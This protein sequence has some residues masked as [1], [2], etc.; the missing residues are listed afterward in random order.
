M[1]TFRY[2]STEKQKRDTSW[3]LTDAKAF[4]ISSPELP[5]TAPRLAFKE[6]R[7]TSQLE[8]VSTPIPSVWR[9]CMKWWHNKKFT[10]N[11]VGASDRGGVAGDSKAAGAGVEASGVSP[12]HLTAVQRVVLRRERQRLPFL[13]KRRPTILIQIRQKLTMMHYSESGQ[14]RNQSPKCKGSAHQS[15]LWVDGTE[16]TMLAQ[17]GGVSH[18]GRITG[19]N[20][21]PG[22]APRIG[23]WVEA[24]CQG[25]PNVCVWVGGVSWG[26]GWWQDNKGHIW[27]MPLYCDDFIQPQFTTAPSTTS[28][29]CSHS[30]KVIM[31][32]P[33]WL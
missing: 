1:I 2:T 9:C 8:P 19:L 29:T 7:K 4:P 14:D 5:G 11:G 6:G 21:W 30:T 16:G 26:G 27:D 12:I 25:A 15:V 33:N 17:V 28:L 18:H 22:R 10:H 24:F 31:W 23:G 32:Q 13:G 20:H 3:L